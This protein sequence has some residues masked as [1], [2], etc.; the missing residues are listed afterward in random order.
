MCL[1]PPLFFAV[2]WFVAF[3][4]TRS[5]WLSVGIS[6]GTVAVLM[7]VGWLVWRRMRDKDEEKKPARR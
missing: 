4:V 2:I 1:L 7:L 5:L 6:A 3:A